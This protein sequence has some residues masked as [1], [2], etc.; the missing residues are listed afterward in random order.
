MRTWM[1]VEDEPDLYEMVL[2]M[3]A[4]LSIE[5]ISFVTG[6]EALE[7]IDEVDS[8][9]FESEIPE[10]AL[11]DIRLPGRVNGVEV[12]A[13]LRQSDTL[14]HI[15]IV[16]MTAYRLSPSEERKVMQQ[17]GADLLLYKPLPPLEEFHDMME[18]LIIRH[19]R[20]LS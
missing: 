16:F 14:G 8:G 3:Y 13:R 10:L 9:Q 20:G 11:L 7:W 17:S 5:G 18:D 19:R 12:A 6:E 2:A 15:V 1:V 4:T